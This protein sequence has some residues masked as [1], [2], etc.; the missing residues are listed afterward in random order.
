[1]AEHYSKLAQDHHQVKLLN[2]GDM[3]FDLNLV[4][5]YETALVLEPDL[6]EFQALLIW[7]E[8]IVII[9]PVWWGTMPAKF[10]ALIDRTFLPGFAFKYTKGKTIP[11]KLLKGRSS[12]LIFTMDTPPL[13]YK[14]VQGDPIYKNLKHTILDFVGIK[15]ITSMY[16]GPVLHSEEKT[17]KVWLDK[18]SKRVSQL[19]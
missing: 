14:I 10:K 3:R 11:D 12:E 7:A 15:N 13:W 17:R 5:G 2:V 8:H 4:D 18:V 6:V 1:M 19:K 16:F 9:V